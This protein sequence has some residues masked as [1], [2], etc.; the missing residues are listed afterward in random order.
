[1]KLV[2]SIRTR[3]TAVVA[4]ALLMTLL[5]VTPSVFGAEDA[6]AERVDRYGD[7][8]SIFSGDLRVPPDTRQR[9]SLI[10]VGG[11]VTI[12]GEVTGDVVV[13]LGSLDNRGRVGGSV[14]GVVADQTH[15]DARVD[16]ELVNVL[17]SLALERT[18][19]SRE[20]INILGSLD[21][22]TDSSTPSV[23]ISFGSWFPSVWSMIFWLRLMRWIGVFVLILILAALVPERIVL[24]GD[25]APIRYAVA[26]FVGILGYLGMLV[27]MGLLAATVIGLPLA[28]VTFWILKW[29]GIAG[30][31][32]AVGRRLG[33]AF[34]REMSLLGAVLLTFALYVAI[35]AAPTPLGLFG[36]V[37]LILLRCVFFL[38]ID[39]PAVGLV[40]LTVA[41]TRTRAAVTVIP[42]PAPKPAEPSAAEPSG[43]PRDSG[44]VIR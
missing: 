40:I 23:N 33:R 30:L 11:H 43:E 38:L 24:I 5:A 4:G 22:D 34:G 3:Q 19:V 37:I 13:I 16:R 39:L 35:S 7:L 21:R 26:F 18:R 31:F 25:E 36:L 17:G 8:V 29:L 42:A 14:T 44:P 12:E 10:C 41:G 1:M 6:V 32:F 27:I 20:M 9:G 28:I 2:R 15:T